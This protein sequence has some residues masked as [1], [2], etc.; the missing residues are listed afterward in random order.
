MTNSKKIRLLNEY[1]EN[2]FGEQVVL[3]IEDRWDFDPDVLPIKYPIRE[4]YTVNDALNQFKEQKGY[5]YE[6]INIKDLQK[7][8]ERNQPLTVTAEYK[9]TKDRF[10]AEHPDYYKEQRAKFNQMMGLVNRYKSQFI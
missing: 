4:Q 2:G 10:F 5:I 9:D 8:I 1:I 3:K 6:G 7:N